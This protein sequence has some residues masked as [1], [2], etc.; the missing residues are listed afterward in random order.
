LTDCTT[1]TNK[2]TILLSPPLPSQLLSPHNSSPLTTPLLPLFS[3]VD[4]LS[5][6]TVEAFVPVRTGVPRLQMRSATQSV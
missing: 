4:S 5:G 2:Y 6:S 1:N 3:R